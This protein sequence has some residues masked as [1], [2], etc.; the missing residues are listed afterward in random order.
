VSQPEP[1]APLPTVAAPARPVRERRT[2]FART[3]VLGALTPTDGGVD[4]PPVDT[5]CTQGID[6]LL[7]PK[8]GSEAQL[9]S[10]LSSVEPGGLSNVGEAVEQVFL[11]GAMHDPRRAPGH[12]VLITDGAAN[13][14]PREISSSDATRLPVQAVARAGMKVLVLAPGLDSQTL[15]DLDVYASVGGAPCAGPLCGG[16]AAWPAGSPQDVT[17]MLDAILT[18][19]ES[20]NVGCVPSLPA[21]VMCASAS[22]TGCASIDVCCA[23]GGCRMRLPC[24]GQTGEVM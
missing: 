3:V 17:D 6:R 15:A 5:M 12:I 16:H 1:V 11:D 20:E 10:A 22:G 23:T 4:L 2:K 14:D 7:V 13:C 21:S 8:I 18:R 19:I 24:A 9:Q